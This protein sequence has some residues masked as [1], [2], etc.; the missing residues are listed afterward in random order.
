MAALSLALGLTSC[1]SELAELTPSGGERITLSATQEDAAA[2]R[3]HLNDSKQVVW[4]EGDALSVFD[5]QNKNRPFEIIEGIG[6]T[7]GKFE[8]TVTPSS[9]TEYYAIYPYTIDMDGGFVLM[10]YALWVMPMRFREFI[11]PFWAFMELRWFC[12]I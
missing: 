7:Q 12:S 3:T 10:A 9:V 5:T 2:T 1:Q 8:G 4:S 6:K 11:S